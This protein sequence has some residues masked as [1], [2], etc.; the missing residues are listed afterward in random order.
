MLVKRPQRRLRAASSITM[1]MRSNRGDHHLTFKSPA[2]SKSLAKR[3]WLRP[4]CSFM[5]WRKIRMS[6][7]GRVAA[8]SRSSLSDRFQDRANRQQ[9]T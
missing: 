3:C 2:Q 5:P 7:I 8:D 9:T 1:T 6:G 4:D